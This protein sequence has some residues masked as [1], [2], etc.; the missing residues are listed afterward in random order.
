L[1]GSLII[2]EPEK[3]VLPEWSSGSEP[4]LMASQ[5]GFGSAYRGEEVL[6][7]H[8]VVAQELEHI[9]MEAIRT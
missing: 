7:I 4:E 5:F 9:P 3:P 2:G 1:F 6:S 8:A